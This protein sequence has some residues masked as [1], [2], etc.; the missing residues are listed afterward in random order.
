[1][2]FSAM[3]VEPPLVEELFRAVNA[4]VQLFALG[5]HLSLFLLTVD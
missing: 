1:M 5:L 3:S 4:A 2:N